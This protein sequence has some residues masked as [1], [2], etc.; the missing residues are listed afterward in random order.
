[1]KR[2]FAALVLGGLLLGV[3]AHPAL[4]EN[5]TGEARFTGPN[6]ESYQVSAGTTVQLHVELKQIAVGPQSAVSVSGKVRNTGSVKM[7]YSYHV[8]FLDKD[9]N[10]I[11]CQNFNLFIDPGKEG[12]VGTFI[13]LPPGEIRKIAYYSVTFYE[14]DQPIGSK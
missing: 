12:P 2:L 6:K 1:M 10:L 14:S 4:A 7:N 3:S 8:A 13:N 11:G 9:K 5:K